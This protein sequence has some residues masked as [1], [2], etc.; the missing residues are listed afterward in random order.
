MKKL[1]LIL[2]VSFL[3]G[4]A[5]AGGNCEQSGVDLLASTNAA[6]ATSAVKGANK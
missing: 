6:G 1:I 2:A 5:Y 3:A 4:S